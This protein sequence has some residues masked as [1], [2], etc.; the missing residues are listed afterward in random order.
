LKGDV[1]VA[2][3]FDLHSNNAPRKSEPF[4]FKS[5]AL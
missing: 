3:S 1:K 5:G 2:V 4:G